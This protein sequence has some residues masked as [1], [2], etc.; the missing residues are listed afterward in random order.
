MF[1][2]KDEEAKSRV[3]HYPAGIEFQECYL[4]LVDSHGFINDA[5]GL[6]AYSLEHYDEVNDTVGCHLIYKKTGKYYNKDKSGNRFIQS[7]Q[8]FK[9]LK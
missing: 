9:L 4:G 2:L 8:L 1:S 6:I 3:E 7:F 5:T